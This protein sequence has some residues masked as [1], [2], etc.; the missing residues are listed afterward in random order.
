MSKTSR[1]N[2]QKALTDEKAELQALG[3]S[4]IRVKIVTG[5]AKTDFFD[6]LQ[7]EDSQIFKVS[8][9][10]LPHKGKANAEIED[11]ISNYFSATAKIISGHTSAVKLVQLTQ[12]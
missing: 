11:F 6:V 1:T 3:V 5:A 4:Y 2:L 9:S 10:A 12:K 8:V 7:G